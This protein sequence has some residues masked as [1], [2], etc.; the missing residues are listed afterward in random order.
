MQKL[1][2][3]TTGCQYHHISKTIVKLDKKALLADE[4]LAG[5]VRDYDNL[6]LKLLD[7]HFKN[8]HKALLEEVMSNIFNVVGKFNQKQITA[9][10]AVVKAERDREIQCGTYES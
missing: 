5:I 7:D 3:V 10:F 2:A 6:L 1:A 8:K 9:S 4:L